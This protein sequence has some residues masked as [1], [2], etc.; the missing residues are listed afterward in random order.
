MWFIFAA[1]L[2]NNDSTVSTSINRIVVKYRIHLYNARPCIA[3]DKVSHCRSMRPEF[4][5]GPVPYF[6]RD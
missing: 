1:S 3:V 4:D 2:Y 5:P 6:H